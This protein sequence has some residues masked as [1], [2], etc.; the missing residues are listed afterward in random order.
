MPYHRS[1]TNTQPRTWTIKITDGFE[2]NNR[3]AGHYTDKT[4]A[5]AAARQMK[6]AGAGAYCVVVPAK[7]DQ[8]PATLRMNGRIEVETTAALWKIADDL[9]TLKGRLDAKSE[10]AGNVRLVAAAVADVITRR[11]GIDDELDAIFM[12]DDYEGTYTEAMRRAVDMKA[13]AAKPLRAIW[14]PEDFAQTVRDANA[15]RSNRSN[16][17]DL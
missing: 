4:E 3:Y 9:D 7:A 14:T 16:V 8:R 2:Q 6:A 1:M 10:E 11:L 17:V 15:H 12:D 5:I 13:E